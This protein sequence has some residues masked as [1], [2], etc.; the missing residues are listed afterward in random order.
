MVPD[1][2]FAGWDSDLHSDPVSGAGS[3]P[4]VSIRS[5]CRFGPGRIAF[6]ARRDSIAIRFGDRDFLISGVIPKHPYGTAFETV[7]VPGLLVD[8]ERR[9]VQ[10]AQRIDRD[11]VLSGAGI[12]QHDEVGVAAETPGREGLPLQRVDLSVAEDAD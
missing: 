2:G 3:V 4:G 11:A 5:V 12:L 7:G 8:P 6:F 9:D 10:A 1:S